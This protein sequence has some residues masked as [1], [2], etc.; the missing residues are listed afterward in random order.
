MF[1]VVLVRGFTILFCLMFG[2]VIMCV[3]NDWFL[4]VCFVVMFCNALLM[5][6]FNVCVICNA[7]GFK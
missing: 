1:N 4:N 6:I 2:S 7:W 5:T 3:F